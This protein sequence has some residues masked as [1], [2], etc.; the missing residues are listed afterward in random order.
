M[1]KWLHNLKIPNPIPPS[2]CYLKQF[3]KKMLK[4]IFDVTVEK[5]DYSVRQLPPKVRESR[6]TQCGVA[7]NFSTG[8]SL[9]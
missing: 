2:Q 6:Y 4:V 8:L 7:P 3:M 5:A 9:L 1:M